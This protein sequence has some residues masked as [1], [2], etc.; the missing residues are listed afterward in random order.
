MGMT[1]AKL[2]EIIFFNTTAF[3]FGFIIFLRLIMERPKII[4]TNDDGIHAPGIQSL[5]RV[6]HDADFADLCII[7]PS[8][9]RSGSGVSITWDQPILIQKIEWKDTDAWAVGGTPAD[10]IKMGERIILEKKPDF[11]VSGINAGSNAGRNVLHSGTIGACI[12][13]VFRGIPGVAFSCENG[14]AP[15]YHVAEKYVLS[16][17]RYVMENPL[18]LG[19]FLNVNFPH[20]AKDAV[21]GFKLTHQGKGRWTENPI[22]HI[23]SEKGPSYWLGGKPEE[24]TEEEDC[25]I[26]WLKKG[27][28]TAVPIHVHELTNHIE[29]NKRKQEFQNYFELSKN[30]K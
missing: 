26:T 14:E 3:F 18:P 21:R 27:Y 28:L 1:S 17:I 20:A 19:C 30:K 7:A 8:Q 16:I 11:I 10:C 24:L 4:I 25:D 22:F 2:R 29:L 15:N 9:E 13:G 12:E 23:E 6:L 5:W